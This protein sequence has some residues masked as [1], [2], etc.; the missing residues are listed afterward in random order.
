MIRRMVDEY[1]IRKLEQARDLVS[2]VAGFYYL[3][4]NSGGLYNRLH[5]IEQKLTSVIYDAREYQKMHDTFKD[6]RAKDV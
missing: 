1:D 6:R 4:A 3:S 2:Q 5:T